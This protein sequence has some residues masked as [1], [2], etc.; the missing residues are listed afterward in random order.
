MLDVSRL[1][2]LTPVTQD[3][4]PWRDLRGGYRLPYDPRPALSQLR[5]GEAM[6]A[7]WEELWNELHHQGDVGDASYA[8]V[9]VLVEIQRVTRSLGWNLYALAACIEVERHRKSNPPIPEWLAD[10]YRT[11]WCELVDLAL[12]DLRSTADPTLIQAALG[13]VAVGRGLLK[14]GFLIGDL[15]A[16]E[17]DELIDARLVW[18]ELYASDDAG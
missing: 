6:D 9:P 15:D 1:P 11:A 5:S 13:A 18:K 12:D 7:A 2:Y 16:S 14:L 10:R 8:S 3:D 4:F 17:L